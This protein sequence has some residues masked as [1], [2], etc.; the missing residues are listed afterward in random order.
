[1]REEKLCQFRGDNEQRFGL[2]EKLSHA[3]GRTRTEALTWKILE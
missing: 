2:S 3:E 1:L